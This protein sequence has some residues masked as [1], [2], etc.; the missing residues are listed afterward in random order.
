MIDKIITAI[1]NDLNRYLRLKLNL[2]Q[3]EEQVILNN[4]VNQDGSVPPSN[5]NKIVCSLVNFEEEKIRSGGTFTTSGNV[6]QNPPINLHLYLMYSSTYQ[7]EQQNYLE[8]LR[9]L[10]LVIS[11]FQRKQ[12]F[13]T[14]NTPDLPGESQKITFNMFSADTSNLSNLWG[15]IGA[16]YMPSVVYQVR[17]IS[18]FDDQIFDEVRD[19]KGVDISK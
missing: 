2:A 3:K 5:V 1:N 12:V 6:R 18:I 9:L 10:S 11:F 13:T 7:E 17:L 19:I 4:L 8:G 16:K 15:T 14:H